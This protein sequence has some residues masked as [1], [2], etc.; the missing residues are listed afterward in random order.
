MGGFVVYGVSDGFVNKVIRKTVIKCIFLLSF[1]WIDFIN[2][3]KK[4]PEAKITCDN[5]KIFILQNKN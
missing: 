2:A 4:T 1:I 5:N 3:E